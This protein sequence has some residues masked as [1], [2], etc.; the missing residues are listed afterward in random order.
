M[1]Y[2]VGILFIRVHGLWGWGVCLAG[3]MAYGG[4]E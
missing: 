4:G 3:S 1:A 2:G